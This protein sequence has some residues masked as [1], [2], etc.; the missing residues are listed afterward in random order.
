MS[1]M[2]GGSVAERSVHVAPPSVERWTARL[3]VDPREQGLAVRIGEVNADG[4][5]MS[6]VTQL[7]E[8][9]PVVVGSVDAAAV[10]DAALPERVWFGRVVDDGGSPVDDLVRPL[11]LAELGPRVRPVLA[12]P[13]PLQGDASD[14]HVS[15]RSDRDVGEVA[16]LRGETGQV[17]RRRHPRSL[18]LRFCR[19]GG[20]L[21]RLRGGRLRRGGGGE[22]FK[23]D[24]GRAATARRQRHEEHTGGEVARQTEHPHGSRG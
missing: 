23:G 21:G 12:R 15:V 3:L 8:G 9:P 24:V 10:V 5:G 14:H 16:A 7:T 4:L 17:A 20:R 11:A 19:R 2:F 18:H 22:R 1:P 13:E 6:D